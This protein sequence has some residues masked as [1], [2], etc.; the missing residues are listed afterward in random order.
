MTHIRLATIDDVPAML[1][2][3]NHY[4]RTTPANFAVEP[5]PTEQWQHEFETHSAAYP[6]L[7]ATES[8]RSS[9]E[10][11]HTSGSSVLGFARSA[12]WKG[13]CAYAFAA[14]TSVYLHPDHRSRGIGRALCEALFAILEAQGYRTVLAGITLPN[15]A[16]VRL[17][18][19]MG[20]KRVALL[21]RVGWKFDRWHDVGY[22]Q[23]QLGDK[24]APPES[25]RAVADVAPAI[26]E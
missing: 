21:E 24:D 20:M 17:H 11:V 3:S 22:W 19:S 8:P 14:E 5:E 18:E 23:M 7:V 16:S 2:I 13:R 15:D 6:W 10:H 25:I 1:D 4:A 26:L 12:P 9:E